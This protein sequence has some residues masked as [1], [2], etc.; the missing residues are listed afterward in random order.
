MKYNGSKRKCTFVLDASTRE[1]LEDISKQTGTSQNEIVNCAV[2][3]LKIID[4]QDGR[5]LLENLYEIRQELKQLKV[6]GIDVSSYENKINENIL[7]IYENF[8][9]LSYQKEKY[10]ENIAKNK[11]I[12]KKKYSRKR[13]KNFQ[14][15]EK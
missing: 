5:L 4:V 7:H 6:Q 13:T 8:D 11:T 14:E 15:V 1:M 9:D 2:K 10:K 3:N 12:C